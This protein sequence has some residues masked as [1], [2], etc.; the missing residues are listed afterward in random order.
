MTHEEDTPLHRGVEWSGGWDG[1]VLMIVQLRGDEKRA[2][3]TT[4]VGAAH[5][6]VPTDRRPHPL[7]LAWR[8]VGGGGVAINHQ[9]KKGSQPP[10]GVECGSGI[11]CGGKKKKKREKKLF[12]IFSNL[13][14]QQHSSA[15]R[16]ASALVLSGYTCVCIAGHTCTVQSDTTIQFKKK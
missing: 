1:R 13:A 11:Q 12:A 14:G 5:G 8:K 4:A 3:T 7:S 9:F 6:A 10:S 2:S 15:G 16:G